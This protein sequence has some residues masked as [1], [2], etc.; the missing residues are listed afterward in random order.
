MRHWSSRAR[1]RWRPPRGQCC[2]RPSG[3]SL[4]ASCRGPCRLRSSRC[5]H[6][7][8]QTS[9]T[10]P[11]RRQPSSRSAR[12]S[13][14]SSAAADGPR[15]NWALRWGHAGHAV[16]PGPVAHL[17][18][19]AHP[20][21]PAGNPRRLRRP[22]AGSPGWPQIPLGRCPGSVMT[23]ASSTSATPSRRC[24][25]NCPKTMTPSPRSWWTS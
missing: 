19:P 10:P 21:G 22:R 6:S 20:I 18:G 16:G 13:S 8:P 12:A 17:L 25:L 9:A 5:R 23:S 7:A 4:P 2:R 14:V 3:T 1:P 15:A 11:R 24:T